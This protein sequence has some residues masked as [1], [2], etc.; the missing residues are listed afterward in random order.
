MLRFRAQS[1]EVDPGT[2]LREKRGRRQRRRLWM[3]LVCLGLVLATMRQLNQPNT[4]RRLGQIFGAPEV[5]THQQTEK[6]PGPFVLGEVGA[7]ELPA[8]VTGG[9]DAVT[10]HE[11]AS[12]GLAGVKDNTYFRPSEHGAWFGLFERLLQMNSQELQ[13]AS[14]GE[15]TYAQLL[16]QPDVYRGE[17]VS[18]RGTMRLEERQEAPANALGIEMYHRLWISP[19]GGGSSLFA[20]YCLELPD[21]FPRGEKLQVPVSVTGYFFKNWSYASQGGLAIAPVVLARSVD[22][23]A[24]VTPPAR[25]TVSSEGIT[26]TLLFA[27]V[28]AAVAVYFVLRKTRRPKRF[29]PEAHSLT[30]PEASSVETIDEQLQRLAETEPRE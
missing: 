14:L 9:D 12:E 21:R 30:F 4:A 16:K 8:A 23:Q 20:V 19:R 26:K 24:P 6:Q 18:L 10:K 1:V 13:D 22:W 7:G 27:G 15:M 3:L 25:R 28:L 11:D 17:V 29:S 5:A 2:R